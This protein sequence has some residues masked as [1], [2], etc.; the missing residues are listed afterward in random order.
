MILVMGGLEY[1]LEWDLPVWMLEE[2]GG[3]L[4]PEDPDEDDELRVGV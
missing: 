3:L 4:G 2:I 1:P